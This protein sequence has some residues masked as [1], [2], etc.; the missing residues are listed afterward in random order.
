VII[1]EGLHVFYSPGVRE[2][3]D[4][5]IFVDISK[6]MSLSRR[7]ERD[8]EE[9]GRTPESVVRQYKL[10]VVPMYEEYIEP[11]RELA[12]LVVDG[13]RPIEESLGAIL[14]RVYPQE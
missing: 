3:L 12:D 6:G 7:V 5:R 14:A 8:V 11:V 10:H 13:E 2:M 9:R 4:L 1:I